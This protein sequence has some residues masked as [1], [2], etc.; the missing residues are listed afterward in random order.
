MTEET[1][2]MYAMTL[3]RQANYASVLFFI[4]FFIIVVSLKLC[5]WEIS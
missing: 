4:V 2:E 3:L 5:S 1:Y